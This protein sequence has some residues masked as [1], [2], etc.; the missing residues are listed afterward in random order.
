MLTL[1]CE[2]TDRE[3]YLQA[4]SCLHLRGPGRVSG[5]YCLGRFMVA[6][7]SLGPLLGNCFK[8]AHICPQMLLQRPGKTVGCC[9]A[10]NR[11]RCGHGRQAR[12]GLG[13]RALRATFSMKESASPFAGL[14]DLLSALLSRHLSLLGARVLHSESW[15]MKIV[16]HGSTPVR[17]HSHEQWEAG[18][19]TWRRVWITA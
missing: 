8:P 6:P 9:L 11:V 3:R 14:K 2:G 17:S 13:G 15:F 7:L 18:G 16:G 19:R 12:P 1:G 4:D 10:R 5:M